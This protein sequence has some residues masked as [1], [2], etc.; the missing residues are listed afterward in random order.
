MA[1]RGQLL[2]VQAG[3]ALQLVQQAPICC[4]QG[5]R[6]VRNTHMKYIFKYIYK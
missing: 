2:V 3:I 6:I 4:I 1:A 5:D